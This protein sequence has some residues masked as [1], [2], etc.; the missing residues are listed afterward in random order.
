MTRF[1]KAILKVDT[2]QSPDG[3]VKVT[4]DRLRHWA[5]TFRRMQSARIKVPVSWGHSDDPKASSP[6][7]PSVSN[8]LPQ[9]AVGRLDSF[10]VSRDGGSARIVLDIPRDEDA[11]KVKA[12]LAEVSPV[13]F[14][15]WTDGKGHIHKDCITHIDLVQHPVDNSQSDF[16][17]ETIA[18]ALRMGLDT[19]KPVTYRMADHPDDH[20]DDDEGSSHKEEPEVPEDLIDDEDAAEDDGAQLFQTVVQGLA[21]LNVVV[22]SDTTPDNFFERAA[23]AILTAKAMGG[24]EDI[25]MGT[26]DLESTQ[27]EF[28]ALSLENKK[29]HAH[30]DGEHRKTVARRLDALLETGRCEPPEHEARALEVKT[31]RLSL[32]TKGEHQPTVTESWIESREAVPAG[33]FWSSEARTR[34]SNLE[35][36]P[37]PSALSGDMV[38]E[39]EADA[40]VAEINKK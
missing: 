31:I 33:T 23:S 25:P 18:C 32:D 35:E 26:E 10:K 20:P 8:R 38:T 6:V 37:H 4:P 5:E 1:S 30:A 12:N 7:D 11:S 17:P 2:Y 9:D 28:A 19:G 34:M 39:E 15:N 16:V 29:W 36:V 40:I 21:A 14:D 24:S 13:I 3:V 22:P 27:P